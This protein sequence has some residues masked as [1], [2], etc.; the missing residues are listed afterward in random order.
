MLNLSS[1]VSSSAFGFTLN[2]MVCLGFIQHPDTI[3]G[4]PKFLSN[5]WL[6]DKSAQWSVNVAGRMVSIPRI[7]P[8]DPIFIFA[9]LRFQ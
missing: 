4:N 2:K 3:A 9:Y 8:D 7:N 5:H 6:M 1:Y